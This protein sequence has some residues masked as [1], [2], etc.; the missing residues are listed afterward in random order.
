M[1][2]ARDLKIGDEFI[3]DRYI[4]VSPIKVLSVPRLVKSVHLQPKQLITFMGKNT[5]SLDEFPIAY[6]LDYKLKL[7]EVEL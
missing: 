2:K 7:V 5:Y 6:E 1:I 3:D 4:E